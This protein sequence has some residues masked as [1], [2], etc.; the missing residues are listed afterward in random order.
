[1][2][3]EGGMT[4]SAPTLTSW[5]PRMPK[6]WGALRVERIS[7]ATPAARQ[8]AARRGPA[9]DKITSDEDEVWGHGVDLGDHLLEEPGFGELLKVDVAHLDDAEVLANQGD[10]G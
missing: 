4:W 5:L 1:M 6:R 9:T 2:G 10:R 3:F 7:A 8:E